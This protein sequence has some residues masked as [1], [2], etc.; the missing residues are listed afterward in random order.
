[1]NLVEILQQQ[2]IDRPDAIAIVASRNGIV[3]HRQSITFTQLAQAA[4]Q[5]A[6]FLQSV[7]LKSGDAV[8]IFQPMSIDLYVALLAIW[9][10]GMV[11]MFVDPAAGKDH[12][13]RCCKLYP[14]QGLIAS[15]KAHLLRFRAPALRRIP[16]KFAIGFPVWGAKRW[17]I[18][19]AQNS[20]VE[21]VVAETP[22]LI[23]F[24]SGS[25]GQPKAALRTHGFLLAQH[26]AIASS[27]QLKPNQ[28]D[29]TTLP[30]FLLANLASGVTSVIP[31]VDLRFPG[32]IKA[33]KVVRQIQKFQPQTIAASPAFLSRLADYC[34]RHNL[35]LTSFDRIYNGGAPVFPRLLDRLQNLAPEAEVYAVYGSTEAEPIAHI[36]YRQLQFEDLMAMQQGGGLLVGKPVAEADVRILPQTKDAILPLSREEFG[37]RC[38]PQ[39]E[40]G[41]IVV[42]GDHVLS[43]YLHGQGDAETKFRV[44]GQAWHRTGDAGYFDWQGRLWLLGRC[45]ARIQDELGVLY[46][47]AVEAAVA[48]NPAIARSALIQIQGQRWLIV[49]AQ[50]AG[51]DRLQENLA[52]AKIDRILQV[53]SIPVDRR[54]NA[55]IDYPTLYQCAQQW[56]KLSP[57]PPAKSV[58]SQTAISKL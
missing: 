34:D 18:A 9:R 15:S 3:A 6:N 53:K 55:K 26:Q 10:L 49:E 36:A 56:A 32:R 42:A 11:A 31:D 45:S 30:I 44:D 14:P 43:G 29:L 41:E 39:G 37:D 28:I 50:A 38:L 4:N 40:I 8:L 17:A 13:D 12:L 48:Q 47:F 46:P 52:W 25:T 2:A 33:D 24:T 51:I 21:P 58:Y 57:N 54:H 27:L 19:A 22:A 1:M 5:A 16:H 7:G 35:K 23:T 20:S